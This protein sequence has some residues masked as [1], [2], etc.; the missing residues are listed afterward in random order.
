MSWEKMRT[1][2]HRHV[3]AR[4]AQQGKAGMAGQGRL[5]TGTLGKQ[6][7]KN[8]ARNLSKHTKLRSVRCVGSQLSKAHT[9]VM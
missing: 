5:E 7:L 1:Q 2:V 4:R 9:C 3:R 8:T 6:N